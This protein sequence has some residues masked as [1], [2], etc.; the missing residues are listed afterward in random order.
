MTPE[1]ISEDIY[2]CWKA[3]AS[4]A[5]IHMRDDAGKGKMDPV[6]FKK[7][8]DSLLKTNHPDC[9]IILNMTT[10]GELAATDEMRMIDL[11]ECAQA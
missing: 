8:A 6:R 3:G 9:D 11:K 4:V 1:E 10:S 5:H 7:T 2:A